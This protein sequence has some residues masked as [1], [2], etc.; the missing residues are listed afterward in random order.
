MSTRPA[1][2]LTTSE[3]IQRRLVGLL[4]LLLIVFL[5][6]VLLR[7]IGH[8]T[9]P[10]D[11]GLQTVVVPLGS[12]EPPQPVVEAEAAVVA[13]EPAAEAPPAEVP[14]PVV[15]KPEAEPPPAQ[16]S[17]PK[18]PPPVA[19]RPE[20]RPAPPS[21]RPSD[22][23]ASPGGWYVVLG[24]FS[25]AANA[26]ALVLR[27]KQSGFPAGTVPVRVGGSTLTRVRVGPFKSEREGQSARATLIVEGMTG[28]KLIRE[29]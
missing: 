15:E 12:A 1:S 27:A 20:S 25:D 18:A 7:L 13:A 8:R 24:T 17:T 5:L 14:P 16:A 21:P 29:P 26:K 28:A 9:A 3:L 2:E 23:P 19:Q 4:V 22:K 11:K 6:S 10:Q